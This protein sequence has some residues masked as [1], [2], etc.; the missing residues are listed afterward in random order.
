MELKRGTKMTLLIPMA[1][2]EGAWAMTPV[3]TQG[4]F[5]VLFPILCAVPWPTAP[6]LPFIVFYVSVPKHQNV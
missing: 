2:L 1:F 6:S 5:Q 4:A 3:Y